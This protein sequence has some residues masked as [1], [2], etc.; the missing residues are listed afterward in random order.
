M[1]GVQN[2][3]TDLYGLK[4]SSLL[5]H[6]LF[7]THVG[8]GQ[9]WSV[10]LLNTT[11]CDVV[12]H[13]CVPWSSALHRVSMHQPL[14]G[15]TC[16]VF[17]L[18]VVYVLQFACV[19]LPF[20]VCCSKVQSSDVSQQLSPCIILWNMLHVSRVSASPPCLT[21]GCGPS[22]TH[23]QKSIAGCLDCLTKLQLSSLL[24]V[25]FRLTYAPALTADRTNITS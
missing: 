18:S 3:Y 12:L 5:H 23:S 9:T 7:P 15:T 19:H 17:S 22:L 4:G 8:C 16:R 11:N 21:R 24:I 1:S 25:G 14:L 2:V 6:W 10:A 13:W 20:N